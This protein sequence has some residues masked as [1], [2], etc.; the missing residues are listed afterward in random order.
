M[1]LSKIVLI[2]DF[3]DKRLS[4]LL[5]Q[6]HL[7]F[8]AIANA[9]DVVQLINILVLLQFLIGGHLRFLDGELF[10]RFYIVRFKHLK[11]LR[12]L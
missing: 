12:V 4:D 9:L 7:K 5:H 1:I 11:L 6:I 10:V 3:L 8:V 2:L